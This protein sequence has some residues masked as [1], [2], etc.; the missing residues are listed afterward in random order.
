MWEGLMPNGKCE[1]EHTDVIEMYGNRFP[2]C[3]QC[4]EVTGPALEDKEDKEHHS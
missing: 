4:G 2:F 1:H 3:M